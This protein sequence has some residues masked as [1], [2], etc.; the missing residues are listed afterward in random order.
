MSAPEPE[1]EQALEKLLTRDDLL[2]LYFEAQECEP[3]EKVA[4]EKAWRDAVDLAVAQRK[5]E[6]YLI[7]PA[8]IKV[9]PR[10]RAKRLG[11]EMP[12]LPFEVRDQ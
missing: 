7:E 8:L 9:Y 12:E 3:N 11:K 10:Y 6:R 5:S 1:Q 2:N 4:K